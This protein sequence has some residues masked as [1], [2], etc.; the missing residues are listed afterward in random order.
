MSYTYICAL[1]NTEDNYTE[2]D[3]SPL[4]HG[5][6]FYPPKCQASKYMHIV[7]RWLM[8]SPISVFTNELRWFPADGGAHAGDMRV[9]NQINGTISLGDADIYILH[10]LTCNV[11]TSVILR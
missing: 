2:A 10:I 11:V 6:N 4:R 8:R 9:I 3:V 1:P 7:L 5:V